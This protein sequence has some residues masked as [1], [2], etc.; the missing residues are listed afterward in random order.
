[1]TGLVILCPQVNRKTTWQLLQVD[2]L[3]NPS[4]VAVF[5]TST[6]P[7]HAQVLRE[8]ETR[9]IGVFKLSFNT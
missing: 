8:L 2:V 3:L 9:C 1:M 4:R 7:D 5:G 6:R